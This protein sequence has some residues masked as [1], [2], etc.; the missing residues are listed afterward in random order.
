MKLEKLTSRMEY[1]HAV[2]DEL[3][4]PI[5]VGVEYGNDN[6]IH[7]VMIRDMNRPLMKSLNGME[8]EALMKTLAECN[9]KIGAGEP[10]LLHIA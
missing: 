5:L 9:S 3:E 6:E 8:L 2:F 7:G 1:W 4:L 10:T